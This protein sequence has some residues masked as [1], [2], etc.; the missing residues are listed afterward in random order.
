MS[1]Q[2]S[3]FTYIRQ[4]L[5]FFRNHFAMIAKIQL[6]FLLLEGFAALMI[7]GSVTEETMGINQG[8][9]VLINLTLLPIYTAA[10]IVYLQSVVQNNPL[11]VSQ[12]IMLGL[13]RWGV[14]LL[15]YIISGLAIISGLLFLIFPGLFILARLAFADYIGVLEKQGVFSSLKASWERTEDYFWILL[16]GTVMLFGLVTGGNMLL[17]STLDGAG[18]MT[19]L[20]EITLSIIF[21]LFSAIITIFGFRVYCVSLQD[22]QPTSQD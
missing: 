4:S 8:L 12:S 17:H 5:Y 14:L 13:T 10:T 3:P 22:N 19:P 15:I 1:E 2:S 9:L 16:T 7:H 20:L 18:M 21:G 6:P 11:R